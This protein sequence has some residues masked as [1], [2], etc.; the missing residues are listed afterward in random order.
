V[1]FIVFLS[2]VHVFGDLNTSGGD[3]AG[4][5]GR[6]PA[7]LSALSL[8]RPGEEATFVEVLQVQATLSNAR[9][10]D[11]EVEALLAATCCL[12]QKELRSIG[13][14]RGWGAAA[15]P[16]REGDFSTKIL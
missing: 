2:C 12:Q 8:R 4:G 10:A 11:V 14:S 9:R 16:Q 13:G 6:H 7:A 1:Y 3:D 5:R 15:S